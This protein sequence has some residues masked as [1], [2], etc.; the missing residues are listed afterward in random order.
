[1]PPRPVGETGGIKTNEAGSTEAAA[2]CVTMPELRAG[3]Y[4]KV[5]R[6]FLPAVSARE[7]AEIPVSSQSNKCPQT[8]I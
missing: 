4:S 7:Q 5:S 6:E 2:H 1:M 8:L 3:V